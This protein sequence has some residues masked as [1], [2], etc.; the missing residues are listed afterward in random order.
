MKKKILQNLS[1]IGALYD[2]YGQKNVGRQSSGIEFRSCSQSTWK[3]RGEGGSANIPQLSTTGGGRG[4]RI[5]TWSQC[6]GVS[7][8][9][10]VSEL[11]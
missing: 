9:F 2:F 3:M 11:L 10:G 4:F 5:P 8:F 7:A 6:F 1:Q